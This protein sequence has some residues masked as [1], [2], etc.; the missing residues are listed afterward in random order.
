MRILFVHTY[1]TGQTAS[2]VQT[3]INILRERYEVEELSL[4]GRASQRK[5]LSTPDIWR[6]VAKHDIVFGWFGSVA[7]IIIIAKLLGKQS[8]LCTGGGDIIDIPEIEYGFGNINPRRRW[9][10]FI[11]FR[12]A[13][14][15]LA[16]SDTSL[17]RML[18]LPFAKTSNPKRVYLGVDIDYF[19]PS[20]K[21]KAQALT[22][23]YIK[24]SNLRRKGILTFIEAACKTPNLPHRLAGRIINPTTAEQIRTISPS[25]FVF[26][27]ELRQDELLGEYQ[28]SIV[29][30]QLSWHE[31]FGLALAE[32]MSCGCIPVVTS[33]GS[34]PEIVG[35]CGFYVPLEDPQAT[36]EAIQSAIQ[37]SN[38]HL[39]HRARERIADCFP[40]QRR[41]ENLFNLID[42]L[43]WH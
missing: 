25:N 15:I 39:S 9:L 43:S 19:I 28:E 41:K 30:A 27:G 37:P 7:P 11:G 42:Q 35:D 20:G 18:A 3:D 17:R 32:A 31:G 23:S 29:Y 40:L 10:M 38:A 4:F 2:F 16:F 22:V 6:L 34:I 13:D 1:P 36:A 8:F 5:L 33:S 14:H 26:L 24:E 21:K 12:L